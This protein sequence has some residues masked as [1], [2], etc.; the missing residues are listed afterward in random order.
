MSIR[1]SMSSPAPDDEVSITL[2]YPHRRSRHITNQFRDQVYFP[3]SQNT[4]IIAVTLV[5]VI[6]GEEY[7]LLGCS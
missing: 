3:G 4:S 7:S 2:I 5:D 6:D 1:R